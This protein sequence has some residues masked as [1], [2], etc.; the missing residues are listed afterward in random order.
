MT[1]FRGGPDRG[2]ELAGLDSERDAAV[3]RLEHELPGMR[4][5]DYA[6]LLKV[7][8]KWQIVG[9]VYYQEKTAK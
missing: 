4:W 9:F 1:A 7:E 5:I 8:G 6:S 3:A 2:S